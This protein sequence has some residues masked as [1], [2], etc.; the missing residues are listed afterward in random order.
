MILEPGCAPGPLQTLIPECCNSSHVIYEPSES[1]FDAYMGSFSK[2]SLHF[3]IICL[4]T[5]VWE[6]PY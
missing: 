6:P 1:L 4:N 5:L 3:D 2:L